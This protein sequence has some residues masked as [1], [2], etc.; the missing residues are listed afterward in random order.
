MNAFSTSS[1]AL[2]FAVMSLSGSPES[3][4]ITTR[5]VCAFHT[6]A[7]RYVFSFFF[8]LAAENTATARAATA[9]HLRD[10]IDMAASLHASH[11]YYIPGA[12]ILSGRQCIGLTIDGG[13]DWEVCFF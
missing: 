6:K 2:R 5:T 10:R 13:S 3:G 8:A 4:R 11:Q 1:C 12:R 7:G 9:I